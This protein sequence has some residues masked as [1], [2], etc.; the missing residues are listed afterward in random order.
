[1]MLS[2]AYSGIMAVSIV[3]ITPNQMRGQITAVYIFATSM[4]RKVLGGN[5]PIESCQYLARLLCTRQQM[6]GER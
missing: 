4:I 2:G 6:A 5:F 3:G 1:M